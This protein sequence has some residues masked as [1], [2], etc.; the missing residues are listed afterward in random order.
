MSPF[1]RR[2]LNTSAIGARAAVIKTLYAVNCVTDRI[3]VVPVRSISLARKEGFN[4]PNC[5]LPRCHLHPILRAQ[6]FKTGGEI[7]CCLA[8]TLTR[9]TLVF[10]KLPS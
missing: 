9:V 10:S 7:L 1:V 2:D 8:S 4:T 3:G 6:T 5:V